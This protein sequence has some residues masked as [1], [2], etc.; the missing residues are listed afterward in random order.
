M[1]KSLLMIL[2]FL[3]IGLLSGMPCAKADTPIVA[4]G[5]CD[6]LGISTM[7]TNQKSIVACLKEDS[8]A[9]VWKSMTD[10]G[11]GVPAGT[12]AFFALAGCPS[13]WAMTN[14]SSGTVDLRGE[15]LRVWD[16]GRGVDA[17]RVLGS[18]QADEIKS[19]KH[20]T[21]GGVRGGGSAPNKGHTKTDESTIGNLGT[22]ATGGVETRPRNV[23]LL[24]CQKL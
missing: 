15:F 12:I 1:R 4:G 13:G 22:T 9:L 24:A 14:G 19:H 20:D 2:S 7:A 17:G 21:Y 6:S 3:F 11:S 5:S 8:G 10:G 23:A 18:A 16:G